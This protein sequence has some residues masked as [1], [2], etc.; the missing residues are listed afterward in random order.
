MKTYKCRKYKIHNGKAYMTITV[1]EGTDDK[2]G[3][4]YIGCSDNH[5]SNSRWIEKD[6]RTNNFE[7]ALSMAKK[8]MARKGWIPTEIKNYLYHEN[9]TDYMTREEVA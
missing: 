6:Y 2:A 9:G 7:D 4:Q 1:S 3:V 5:G 8:Y